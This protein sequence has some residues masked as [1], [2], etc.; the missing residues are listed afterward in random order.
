MNVFTSTAPDYPLIHITG[1]ILPTQIYN[2]DLTDK[3]MSFYEN[4]RKV[5]KKDIQTLLESNPLVVHAFVTDLKIEGT[6]TSKRRK[7][8]ILK[9]FTDF[10]AVCSVRVSDIFDMDDLQLYTRSAIRNAN[11]NLFETL[12]E[13][14]LSS[15]NIVFEKPQ[16][17][18]INH[19]SKDQI[20]KLIGKFIIIQINFHICQSFDKFIIF[21][22]KN[23]N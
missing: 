23:G 13:K 8:S 16:K 19:K 17:I 3:N 21:L 5:M 10:T 1:S 2:D 6:E 20:V 7:R 12:D 15:F 11:P 4:F 22:R 14:S 18:K 9:V